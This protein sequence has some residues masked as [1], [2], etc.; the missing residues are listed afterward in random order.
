M[1]KLIAATLAPGRTVQAFCPPTPLKATGIRQ[2]HERY[3]VRG[4]ISCTRYTLMQVKLAAALLSG[5]T[6]ELGRS[7]EKTY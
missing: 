2:R 4:L 7:G 5:A 6:L 1:S 3:A